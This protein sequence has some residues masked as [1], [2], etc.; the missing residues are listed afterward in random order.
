MPSAVI[1]VHNSLNC[2]T[3]CHCSID[4]GRGVPFAPGGIGSDASH[5]AV[6]REGVKDEVGGGWGVLI[7]QAE[8]GGEVIEERR[9]GANPVGW[10]GEGG[11]AKLRW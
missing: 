4:W 8:G 3:S 5:T 2:S 11:G 7:P 10:A 1:V 6:S 9:A